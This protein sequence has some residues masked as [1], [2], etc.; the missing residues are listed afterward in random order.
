[1]IQEITHKIT[2]NDSVYEVGTLIRGY[3]VGGDGDSG[4][5]LLFCPAVPKEGFCGSLEF[6]EKERKN[7]EYYVSCNSEIYC[8]LSA[9]QEKIYKKIVENAGFLIPKDL[10]IVEEEIL[11]PSKARQKPKR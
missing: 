7:S 5:W 8:N 2:L 6:V 4:K 3:I 9:S 11:S 1:M 10:K